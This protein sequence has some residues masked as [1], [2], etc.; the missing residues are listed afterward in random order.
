MKKLIILLLVLF[1]ILACAQS[2]N[3]V[4]LVLGDSVE[5]TIPLQTY[6]RAALMKTDTLRT[7]YPNIEVVSY[8]CSGFCRNGDWEYRMTSNYIPE[9][10]KHKIKGCGSKAKIYFSNIL[11]AFKIATLAYF[12]DNIPADEHIGI[13]NLF[14]VD[15]AYR[16][17]PDEPYGF[18]AAGGQLR[19]R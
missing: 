2:R 12:Y 3:E 19:I 6:T 13:G 11:R 15:D 16:A 5:T 14:P 7:N 17:L 4:F 9:T 18:A 10:L 1:P 8:S